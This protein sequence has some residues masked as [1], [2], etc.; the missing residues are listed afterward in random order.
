MLILY[1]EAHSELC[2]TSINYI[3]KK[4]YLRYGQYFEYAYI[5]R[6][7][8]ISAGIYLLKV[9]NKNTRTRFEICSKLIIK[10][11]DTNGAILVSLLLT[12]NIFYTYFAPVFLL[13]T[14]TR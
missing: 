2:Q 7:G 14:L 12:L 5:V 11:N 1:R 8:F 3:C 9:N 13:L 6:D 4:L 10:I